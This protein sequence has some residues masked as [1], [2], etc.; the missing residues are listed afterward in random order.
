LNASRLKRLGLA[1]RPTLS[2]P[3]ARLRGREDLIENAEILLKQVDHIA[4]VGGALE[5]DNRPAYL[6]SQPEIHLLDSPV[7][8]SDFPEVPPPRIADDRF[9]CVRRRLPG[10]ELKVQALDRQAHRL[11]P[12]ISLL[13]N[14]IAKVLDPPSHGALSEPSLNGEIPILKPVDSPTEILKNERNCSPRGG[15]I[16]QARHSP[17]PAGL[18]VSEALMSELQRLAC[19]RENARRCLVHVETLGGASPRSR[20]IGKSRSRHDDARHRASDASRRTGNTG[21]THLR[22]GR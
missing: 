9:D 16:E 18:V 10:H 21:G 5:D 22:L 11:G 12:G 8:E 6:G 13:L 2:I 3:E 4:P 19:C 20:R 14:T 7:I 15:D 1:E 17:V